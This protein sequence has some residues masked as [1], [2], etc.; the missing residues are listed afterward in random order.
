MFLFSIIAVL[1]IVLVAVIFATQNAVIIP[2]IFLYWQFKG[3]LALILF[4]S[5][6]LGFIL[7]VAIVL[8]KFFKKS[9]SPKKKVEGFKSEGNIIKAEESENEEYKK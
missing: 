1:I 5:F 2:L 4:L 6:I 8:P 7:G 3:S 9:P